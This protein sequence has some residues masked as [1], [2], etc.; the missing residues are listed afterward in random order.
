MQRAP[1]LEAEGFC[2][3]KTCFETYIKSKDI[4]L[5]QVIQNGNFYF[6]I[7][8]SETKM[9][10]E[11]LCELLKKDQKKQLSKNNEAKMILY[12]ALSRN[13]Q[14]KDCKIDLF[15]QQYEKFS[16]SD[17]ETIDSG[18]T[19]FNAIVTS[20]KSLDQDNSSKNHVRK[21][22]PALP[23]KWRAK[24]TA[25]EEA[26]DL[27]ALPLDELI[28][29]LK[30]Y[31]KILENYGVAS[32]TTK[33]KVKSL[34][35][36]ANVTREQTSDDSSEEAAK[37]D[38]GTKEGKALDKGEVVTIAGKKVTSL[39]SV[40]S[41]RITRI[42]SEELGVIVKTVCLKCDLLPDDWIVDSGC[43]KHMTGN[44]RLFTS[45]KAYDGGHVVFGSNLKGKV[46][47]GVIIDQLAKDGEK[48]VFWSTNDEIQESLLNLKNTMYHSRQII[49]ISRLRRIQDHCMTLKNTPHIMR[50]VGQRV[51]SGGGCG[52]E[53]F[54]GEDA[55]KAIPNMGFN[56][57]NVEG[58]L[59]LSSL[60]V[61]Q[62]FSF[63]LQMGFTLILATLD[64]LDVGLLG[65]VIGEDDCDDDG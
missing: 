65:D 63:F 23:L 43:T 9:M 54:L 10:K 21:F 5:W 37:I 16:I 39:L 38:L 62:G 14:V 17:E 44:R 61:L 18:F 42:L 50:L 35:L 48:K 4:D 2:F 46:I 33:E 53:L 32:K 45:Y 57:V 52:R 1:L 12:N 24:V 20:L 51:W 40:Q 6:E 59:T 3:S 13:S 60:D 31:Q 34:A 27:A 7:E 56:L 11:T 30:V 26:K 55:T 36:K 58:E 47:G 29:N 22:L 49:R 8:D 64:G 15:T 25:I 41:P 19:R 28:G